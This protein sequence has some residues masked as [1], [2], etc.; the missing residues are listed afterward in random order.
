MKKILLIIMLMLLALNAFAAINFVRVD[1]PNGGEIITG[2]TNIRFV[3]NEKTPFASQLYANIYYSSVKDNEQAPNARPIVF[4][5]DLKAN[6]SDPD[7]DPTT[8]QECIYSWDTSTA[9]E[10]SWYL[11][12]AITDNLGNKKIDSSNIK[13]Y[14]DNQAP[15]TTT[16]IENNKWYNSQ[17]LN[18]SFNC[19]D[20]SGCKYS[21]YLLD[22]STVGVAVNGSLS[23]E[24]KNQIKET[25][26]TSIPSTQWLIS[27][28][29]LSARVSI[30]GLH[31]LKFFSKDNANHIESLNTINFGLDTLNPLVDITIPNGNTYNNLIEFNVQKIKDSD[32]NAQT[33]TVL[34]NDNV[35]NVFSLNNCSTNNGN[36][37]CSYNETSLVRGNTYTIKVRAKDLATNQGEDSITFRYLN[38]PEPGQN[39][40]GLIV[41]V[42]QPNGNQYIKGIYQINLSVKENQNNPLYLVLAYSTN[43]GSFQNIIVNAIQLNT[44]NC[45]SNDFTQYVTCTFDWN[46]FNVTDGNYFIDALIFDSQGN[47]ARDSSDKSFRVDNTLPVI[48]TN[49]GNYATWQ[50]SDFNVIF[51]VTDN[52]GIT[53]NE[54]SVDNSSWIQGNNILIST[55]G[56]HFIQFRATDLAGNI[57]RWQGYVL[58][59]KSKPVFSNA[60]PEPNSYT[61]DVNTLITIKIIDSLSGLNLNSI[62][63]TIDPPVTRFPII[64]PQTFDLSDPELDY[65]TQNNTLTLNLSLP[66]EEETYTIFVY[67][68][69]NVGNDG[70][71]SWSFTVDTQ[72]TETIVDLKAELT[73]QNYVLLS[74]T[75]IN[76]CISAY[77]VYRAEEPITTANKNNYLLGYTT[78]NE[79]LDDTT[80]PGKTYYYRVSAIDCAGNESS[81][82]N[83]VIISIPLMPRVINIT[84]RY[85]TVFMESNDSIGVNYEI[86]NFSD[87]NQC[88]T[89]N[90]DSN[91]NYIEAETSINELCLNAREKTSFTLTVQTINA[92]LSSFIVRVNV[93]T[94]R[95]TERAYLNVIVTEQSPVSVI[96]LTNTICRQKKEP[97]QVQLIN[98]TDAPKTVYLSAS[99]EMFLPYFETTEIE[100]DAFQ[101]KYVDLFVHTTRET[102]PGDYEVKVYARVDGQLIVRN[103]LFSVEECEQQMNATFI[104]NTSNVCVNAKKEET[105][106]INAT[107]E[108]LLNEK[109]TIFL[110]TISSIPSEIENEV[111]LEPLETKSLSFIVKPRIEDA[112]GNTTVKLY[113]WN[114][115]YREEKIACV[116]VLEKGSSVLELLENNIKIEKEETKII[117]FKVIN[118][119]DIKQDYL[120]ELDN[121]SNFKTQLT[122]NNFELNPNEEKTIYLTITATDQK[123]TEHFI[124]LI[125]KDNERILSERIYIKVIELQGIKDV[126][127]IVSPESI[128]IKPNETKT[129]DIGVLNNANETKQ[130]RLEIENYNEE[131][132]TKT[133]SF[134][135]KAN[136]KIILKE[137]IITS[138]N[139]KEGS[140]TIKAQLFEGKEKLDEKTIIVIVKSETPKESNLMSAFVALVTFATGEGAL[141]LI[142]LVLIIIALIILFKRRNTIIAEKQEAW[143][144]KR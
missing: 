76:D 126:M 73:Q 97:I 83:M 111:T 117:E 55:D 38:Y 116:K 81:L 40:N 74:W 20:F 69:D 89:I 42:I 10:G 144:V 6:C 67:A 142:V 90:A 60:F 143:V 62:Y 50:N 110:Q 35:S 92:P 13:F 22:N 133:I 53:I 24:E 45:N 112:V 21:A 12:V 3:Y 27:S 58:L 104:L 128:E 100:L 118:N 141:A 98:N 15:T 129:I 16:N 139:I 99:N 125:V 34:I 82:S 5:F 108:N 64:P 41:N 95:N 44:S 39:N 72:K 75:A 46:T 132:K 52:S 124:D 30:N 65:N 25:L 93:S 26:N 7:N 96:P 49:A 63:L 113:A 14:L 79:A 78:E 106:L 136:E 115:N 61:N 127:I 29:P 51:N 122:A 57:A 121:P 114:S 107:I 140:Y 94:A 88:I 80:E 23:D 33:I 28:Y 135:L 123:A 85:D 138:E 18:I 130:L 8:D 17:P 101:Q 36:Y 47:S 105:T 68:E 102:M 59:D 19:T 134:T 91:S 9:E 86:E 71:Y 43:A 84:P 120:I 2:S 131:I 70:N 109:Q 103:A 4:D 37:Y 66:L 77:Y 32:I 31:S 87:S 1:Y 54:Y 119:G 56:N 11:V 137:P 48:T